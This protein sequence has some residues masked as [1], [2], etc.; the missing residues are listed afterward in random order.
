MAERFSRT[1]EAYQTL[2]AD[3]VACRL[4]PGAALRIT[5]LAG[6]LSVSPGSVR[7]AL[8]RL[9]SEGLVV[10]EPQRGFSASPISNADLE[11]ITTVRSDIDAQCLRLAI[12]HGD[13]NWEARVVS[14]LHR[15]SRIH[16]ALNGGPPWLSAGY[17]EAHKGFHEALVSGCPNDWYLKLRD[18][19]FLLGDR[20]YNLFLTLRKVDSDDFHEHR[21]I[22]DATLG[23]DTE[24]AV[25]LLTNHIW[26]ATRLLQESGV[27]DQSNGI[28]ESLEG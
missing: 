4:R 17:A 10:S 24:K 25:E 6:R 23:R 21:A 26:V 9:A 13:I 1:Y 7:E 2:R 5:E 28:L 12:E 11:D 27:V 20:Y 22:A 14:A 15:L 16:S 8:S 19:L 3:L 18:Q